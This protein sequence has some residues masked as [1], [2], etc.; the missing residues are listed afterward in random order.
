M[1]S[2]AIYGMAKLGHMFQQELENS[3]IEVKY[4]IDIREI[5]DA[6]VPIVSPEEISEP[7]DLIIVTAVTDFF[8]LKR[9]LEQYTDCKIEMLENIIVEI[10]W[11]NI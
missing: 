11:E 6:F 2:V 5:N 4:G 7:V 9:R 1:N 8:A 3:G 10:L